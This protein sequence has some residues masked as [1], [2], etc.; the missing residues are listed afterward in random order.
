MP[1]LVVFFAHCGS[2]CGFFLLD[3][4][5]FAMIFASTA[6]RK[7]FHHMKHNNPEKAI[8]SDEIE[9]FYTQIFAQP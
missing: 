4:Y 9:V 1:D 7:T 3:L 2:F 6:V 5:I 8:T